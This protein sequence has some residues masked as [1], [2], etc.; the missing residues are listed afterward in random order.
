[1]IVK[2]APACHPCAG[3][4]RQPDELKPTALCHLPAERRRQRR[5][6]GPLTRYEELSPY[7][8]SVGSVPEG[9]EAVNIGW[10]EEGDDFPRGE[11][12]EEFVQSLRFSQRRSL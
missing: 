9:V 5:K 4:G 2:A 6:G 8:Y 10:L 7:E 11:V 1:M 12:P 3:G